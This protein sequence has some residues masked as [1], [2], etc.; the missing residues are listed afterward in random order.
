MPP[1]L[2]LDPDRLHTHA[3]RLTAVLDGLVPLPDVD[4]E[5]RTALASTAAGAA[6]LAELDRIT[7]M[8]DR[9]ARELSALTAALHETAAAAADADHE[10][11][12]VFAALHPAQP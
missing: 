3:R 2:H 4:P 5:T 7:A 12:A 11:A 8:V 1:Q 10:A 9:A 6:A